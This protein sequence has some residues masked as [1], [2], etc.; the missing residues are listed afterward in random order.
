MLEPWAPSTVGRAL[1]FTFAK[2]TDEEVQYVLWNA[3]HY[4]EKLKRYRTAFTAQ[5]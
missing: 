5:D 4:V 2:L 3:K 1:N